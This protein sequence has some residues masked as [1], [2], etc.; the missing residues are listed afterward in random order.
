MHSADPLTAGDLISGPSPQDEFVF[1]ESPGDFGGAS[2]VS[3]RNGLAVF[4]GTIVWDGE[5][6][7]AYPKTW[8]DPAELGFGCW[9]QSLAVPSM[10]QF[11]LTGMQFSP[12][13]PTANDALDAVWHSALPLGLAQGGY[14]FDVVALLYPRSVGAFNPSTAEWVVLVNAGWLE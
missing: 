5:G 12:D 2:A 1:Y 6:M 11:D 9:T 13:G 3:A 8:R 14:I 10:R 4:G 7:V